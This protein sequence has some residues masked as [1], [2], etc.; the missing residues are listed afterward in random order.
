MGSSYGQGSWQVGEEEGEPPVSETFHAHDLG[1]SETQSK[2]PTDNSHLVEDVVA[3][4]KS[5]QKTWELIEI[6][7]MFQ[8]RP[9]EVSQEE[10]EKEGFPSPANS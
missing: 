2:R 3:L 9:N 6:T 10:A 8:Q 5:G 4:R 7:H 1:N